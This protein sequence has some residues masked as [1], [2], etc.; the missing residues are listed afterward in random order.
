[1]RSLRD[2]PIRRK[3]TTI[4][5]A[6]SGCALL[7]ITGVFL[8]TTYLVVRRSVRSDMITQAAIGTFNRTGGTVTVVGTVTQNW[9]SVSF[10]GSGRFDGTI[11]MQRA[12]LRTSTMSQRVPAGRPASL[13]DVFKLFR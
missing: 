12:G 13:T 1:M 6:T 9:T 11:S 10:A 5:I 7:I 8:A 4:G 3:L 2:V